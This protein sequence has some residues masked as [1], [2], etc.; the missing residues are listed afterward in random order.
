MIRRLTFIR[1]S[2]IKSMSKQKKN[3]SPAR[4]DGTNRKL[5]KRAAKKTVLRIGAVLLA[6]LF[7]LTAI[8]VLLPPIVNASAGSDS[9]SDS[10]SDSTSD[11][12]AGSFSYAG[13]RLIRVGIYFG[14][15]A[16]NS[17]SFTSETGFEIG[18]FD[19]SSSVFTA[20]TAY[21][22]NALVVMPND[23][24]AG[25]AAVSPDW[26][27]SYTYT[28][29]PAV[30]SMRAKGGGALTLGNNSYSGLIE[31][32]YIAGKL[33]V[34]NVVPLE[35]Y[36]K[37]VASAEVYASWPEE[38]LKAQAV[39]ARSYTL[40]NCGTH[41]SDGFDICADTHCQS[42]KGI[43]AI[44]DSIAAAVDATRGLIVTYN[45]EV[46]LTTYH[47]SS[48]ESTESAAGAWGSDP[49]QYPYLSVVHTGFDDC[50]NY[51]NG[52]WSYTVSAEAL[53]EYINE[54]P[55][56]AGILKGPVERIDCEKSDGSDYV[57]RLTVADA[58]GNEIVV[59]RS[60]NVR[61]FLN[62]YCKSA[63]FRISSY[64]PVYA[65][66]SDAYLLDSQK[67]YVI[68]A[69]GE[70]TLASPTSAIEA[71]TA[72]G[73]KPVQSAGERMFT[74]SGEGYGHG[75]GL[76]QYGAMTLAEN[77]KN[78]REIIALYYPGTDISDG[79]I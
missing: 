31:L 42:Y 71:L 44:A 79:G 15:G 16:V 27:W 24:P 3:P 21:E 50:E 19:A 12:F 55:A 74:I 28:E 6:L 7:L 38:A 37:G 76:S 8:S 46:A 67:M 73:L 65:G 58:L 17:A 22:G 14:S 66:E 78:F 72:S 75:V 36:V 9:D 49:A 33:R 2:A 53:A 62:S 41:S 56:Y 70:K 5:R 52:K 34:V 61:S 43:G 1:F 47:S 63:C 54:K 69:E 45:G 35:D 59:E 48:G 4:V 26:S 51:V 11:S 39:V 68:T 40:Y 10:H 23:A 57:N 64:S 29:E 25:V 60:A 20:V 77:G 13:N 18:L 30:L 32:S